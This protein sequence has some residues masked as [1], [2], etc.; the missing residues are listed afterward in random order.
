MHS[1]RT[2][3]V[4]LLA[5]SST[6]WAAPS[7]VEIQ[8]FM[9][10][11]KLDQ[12]LAS[13]PQAVNTQAK[14]RSEHS[15]DP[16][17]V[18]T[19][20]TVLSDK[21]HPGTS[22]Q[23]AQE[24]LSKNADENVVRDV[25]AWYKTPTGAKIASAD[26]AFTGK[27]KDFYEYML[28]L[29]KNP[30]AADRLGVVRKLDEAGG[31]SAQYLS[32]IENIVRSLAAGERAAT[33]HAKPIDLAIQETID[34]MHKQL[35]DPMQQQVVASLL[36]SYRDLPM[37]TLQEYVAFLSS[38]TG[39]AYVQLVTDAIDHV[40]V[41]AIRDFENH[42]NIR[43]FIASRTTSKSV[44]RPVSQNVPTATHAWARPQAPASRTAVPD[45][46]TSGPPAVPQ[47]VAPS[48]TPVN[49][50]PGSLHLAPTARR[51][52]SYFD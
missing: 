13:V 33:N 40:F 52:P 32:V 22:F 25:L 2:I 47:G 19:V 27:Q 30:P 23:V 41:V 9:R 44:A 35:R 26:A 14:V 7:S 42:P 48:N 18:D 36:Y 38:R 4:L 46:A 34:S 37:S 12:V 49:A 3:V 51:T 45:V 29:A 15:T 10:V 31:F 39:R 16:M 28:G 5:W 8:E 43:A 50:P 24:F 21:L 20:S 1:H 11:T 17:L 6:L